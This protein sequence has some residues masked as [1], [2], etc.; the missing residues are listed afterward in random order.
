MAYIFQFETLLYFD[1][2]ENSENY[3]CTP[4]QIG[5]TYFKYHTFYKISVD[6]TEKFHITHN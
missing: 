3:L 4:E 6:K 1:F 2:D 5:K